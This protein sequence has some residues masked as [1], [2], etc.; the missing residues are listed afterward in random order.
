MDAILQ[1]II[2]AEFNKLSPDDVKKIRE[3]DDFTFISQVKDIAKI[4]FLRQETDLPHLMSQITDDW[5]LTSLKTEFY[6]IFSKEEKDELEAQEEQLLKEFFTFSSNFRS[7]WKRDVEYKRYI[8][9]LISNS[10]ELKEKINEVFHKHEES[11]QEL[12]KSLEDKDLDVKFGVTQFE[13]IQSAKDEEEELFLKFQYLYLV[14]LRGASKDI[15]V[16]N[17]DKKILVI[18]S[19]L[20]KI[21]FGNFP[22]SDLKSDKIYELSEVSSI[23]EQISYDFQKSAIRFF[24]YYDKNS[25]SDIKEF[26]KGHMSDALDRIKSDLIAEQIISYIINDEEV[27]NEC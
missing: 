14:F 7:L 16:Q 11:L 8:S 27:D 10:K 18:P 20:T 6:R 1:A 21:G 15:S 9:N 4:L 26:V 22:L 2:E 19:S 13:F 24:V 12:K 5:L 25:S 23:E 3:E 17:L